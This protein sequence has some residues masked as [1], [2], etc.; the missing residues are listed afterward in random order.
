MGVFE[1]LGFVLLICPFIGLLTVLAG[2]S[3]GEVI[4]KL[5]SGA[6]QTLSKY[7]HLTALGFGVYVIHSMVSGS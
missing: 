7:G 1:E 5:D 2:W 6:W 4:N 3:V